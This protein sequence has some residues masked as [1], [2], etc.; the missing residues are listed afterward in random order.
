MTV[1]GD[2]GPGGARRSLCLY[3]R[4]ADPSGM[5][6]HLLELAGGLAGRMDVTVLCRTGERVRWLFEAASACGARA[7]ALPGPHDPAYPEVLGAHLASH[8]VD[9][10]H[11]HAG[12]RWE[13]PHGLRLAAAAGVPAV[14][15]THHL[16]YLLRHPGKAQRLVRNTSWAHWRIAVSDTLRES[17]LA[18]GVSPERFVTVPNGIGPRRQ[19]PG[20]A[21]ARAALRLPA[22]VPV[23]LSTGRLTAVKDHRSLIGAAALLAPEHPDLQ[24]VVLGEGELRAELE[25]LVA[26]LGLGGVVHLPG[27]RADARALLDAAD[28]FVLPSRAEGMPLTVLEA[29][30]AGLPVVATRGTGSEEAVVHGRTGLLVPP[31]E[32]GELAA[33]LG[34]LLDDGSVRDRY[35]SAGHQRYLE[36]FTVEAMLAGTLAVYDAALAPRGAGA[37]AP[38][39]PTPVGPA[40]GG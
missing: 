38:G 3:T 40:P 39:G 30:E 21:A 5:G 11:C 22:Q 16:S 23:V 12:W 6:A 9:V 36:H 19:A 4:S 13:D 20:R 28:V 1:P 8:P 37:R 31:G 2:D 24:V 7:V 14:V 17:Y 25:G 34:A 15:I 18:R 32:P 10:F 26:A 35:G 33:A 27:H 29:M